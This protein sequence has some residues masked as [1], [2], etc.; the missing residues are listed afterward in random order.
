VPTTLETLAWHARD[1]RVV[2]D[3]SVAIADLAYD[4]RAVEPGTLFFCVPGSRA[5]GHDFAA[6]A[7]AAGAV[8]LV[9][10]RRLDHAVPQVVVDSVRAAMG[11]IAAAFFGHPSRAMTLVG[12]TGTNGKTTT[13]FMIESAFRSM[14]IV[15][16]VTGTVETHVGDEILP[17]TR[18]TP[19]SVDVER[20]LA[21]MRDA[22]VGGAAM[23]VSSHGLH[24]GRV[25]GVRFACAVFTNLSQDHLDYHRT[26]EEYFDAKA[27]LFEHEFTDRAVVNAGD[28]WGARL[29]S[30]TPLPSAT[31]FALDRD[32]DVRALEI[33]MDSTGS[34]VV[35]DA[36][37]ERV[38]F[39]V[40]LPARYNVANALGVLATGVALDW[41]IDAV[42]RGIEAV[43]GVP[44]RVE[45]IDAGQDFTVL[46]DYAHTPDALE[47]V[48][49]AAREITPA[50][51]RL[52][53]VFGCGGDRDR[54]KR[55]LMGKAATSLADRVIITSDNPRSEDPR[56]IIRE[57][58]AGAH[59]GDAPW[60]VI[61][62]RRI[63]IAD[64]INDGATGDVIVIAGKGHET[65]QEFAD[66]TIPFDDR[67]VAR[68]ALEARAR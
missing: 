32:A 67:A 39:R 23:E 66:R 41:P 48:L 33:A 37:G 62:D 42:A 4:S 36:R 21:R 20:L 60:E 61:V 49:L 15:S 68:E 11:P 40:P 56:S 12:V 38:A 45:R 14:G 5:D 46:V 24:Q 35:A 47:G 50:G 58:E 29:L 30:R 34:T 53:A 52:V 3:G 28:V 8:A 7:A 6:A 16:G 64:A 65:G 51:G 19:E 1:A 22:G 18:T 63:A 59:G 2:G 27:L 9:V 10:E 57:I 54:A 43:R 44:G 55:P 13:A 17:V 31:T 26:M 25:D